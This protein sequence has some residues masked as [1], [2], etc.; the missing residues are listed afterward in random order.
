[1][2]YLITSL[3]LFTDIIEINWLT[4][5]HVK[6]ILQSDITAVNFLYTISDESLV[7]CIENKSLPNYYF[8]ILNN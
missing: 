6:G 2:Q 4:W 8:N 5:S 1:M 7:V 3:Y